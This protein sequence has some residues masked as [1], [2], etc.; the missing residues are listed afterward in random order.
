[1]RAV[2]WFGEV[3][4]EVLNGEIPFLNRNTWAEPEEICFEVLPTSPGFR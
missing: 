3:S 2:L 4:V 1:M